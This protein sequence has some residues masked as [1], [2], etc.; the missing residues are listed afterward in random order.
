MCTRESLLTSIVYICRYSPGQ[1]MIPYTSASG[2]TQ[3]R[4]SWGTTSIGSTK[5]VSSPT[6]IN[7]RFAIKLNLVNGE[8]LIGK[9]PM[10]INY[11]GKLNLKRHME[12]LMRKLQCCWGIFHSVVQTIYLW[13][14]RGNASVVP[15]WNFWC[16]VRPKTVFMHQYFWKDCYLSLYLI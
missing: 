14:Y 9:V 2:Y 12:I 16:S 5:S 1:E 7:A 11:H 15:F 6:N 8:C 10:F 4:F 3:N 13:G